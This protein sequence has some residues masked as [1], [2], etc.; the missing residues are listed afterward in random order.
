ML[1]LLKSKMF[2]DWLSMFLLLKKNSFE[3]DS[4]DIRHRPY[5]YSHG[6]VQLYAVQEL[7][8]VLK[9]KLFSLV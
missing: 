8:R 5:H 7:E 2:S 3:S 1:E 9:L 6:V 4:N